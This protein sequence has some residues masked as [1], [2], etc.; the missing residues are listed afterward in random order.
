[1]ADQP[2][3]IEQVEE[4]FKTFHGLLFDRILQ[5]NIKKI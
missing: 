3:A 2:G 5:K 1:M 4:F